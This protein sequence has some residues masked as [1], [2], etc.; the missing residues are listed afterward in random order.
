MFN[1]LFHIR[2]P[3]NERV[4]AYAPGSEERAELKSELEGML[5]N[6][7]EVSLHFS[8]ARYCGRR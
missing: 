7:V 1:G 3:K 5:R 4:L 6:P 2:E 8:P